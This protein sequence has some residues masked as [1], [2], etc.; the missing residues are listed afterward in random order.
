MVELL[1]YWRMV[2]K[3]W[4]IIVL[5][6]IGAETVAVSYVSRQT[7]LYRT[8][9][10]L[11]ITPSTIGAVLPYELAASVGTL[12][13]TYAEYLQR[14]SFTDRV[15]AA[16]A[17]R[18]SE[19]E[20]LGALITSYVQ[21]TPLFRITATHPNP[22]LAQEMANVTARLLIEANQERQ[23]QQQEALTRAQSSPE[24]LS[25]RERLL[26]LQ[27]VLEDEIT[28]YDEQIGLLEARIGALQQGPRSAQ[29]DQEILTLREQ[30]ITYR[31][32][33]VDV[34]SNLSQNAASMTTLQTDVLNDTDAAIIVDEAPLPQ[35]PLARDSLKPLLAALAAAIAL[36]IGLAWALEYLDYTIKSPEQLDELYGLPTQGAI[37]MIATSSRGQLGRGDLVMLEAPRTPIAEAIRALRTSVRMAGGRQPIRNLMVTSAV[38]GEGKTFVTTNLAVSLAQAG[39]RVILVDLDLRRPSVYKMLDLRPDPGFTDLVVEHELLVESVLQPT[40]VPNLRVLT[41]GT[42]PRNP[43]ELLSVERA[44]LIMQRLNELAD[45][46]IYDTPPAATVTDAVILASQMDGVLQVIGAGKTRINV[47]LR[48]KQLL[49]QAGA[50]LIG[51]VLNQI[52]A[53]NLGY[54]SQSYHYTGYYAEESKPPRAKGWRTPF[55]KQAAPKSKAATNRAK[56]QDPGFALVNE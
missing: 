42:I 1:P 51:P 39:K 31:S 3:R 38:P 9:T 54:Y 6:A 47:V 15:V 5:L 32:E 8:S 21:D 22:A 12:A 48:C 17:G 4:W 55:T 13:S 53:D 26:A 50:N 33:R 49:E 43:S 7:P 41:S 24:R 52:D 25:E 14:Q 16:M 44:D 30:A 46:V 11:F 18:V 56:P 2:R 40:P 20:V 35:Q 19:G 27:K 10:T 28:Y 29:V 37:S 45:I 34:L 36:G 23:R